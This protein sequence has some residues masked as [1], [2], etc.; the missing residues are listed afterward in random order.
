MLKITTTFKTAARALSRNPLRS[1]L[2]TLGIVVGIASAI[3]VVQIGAGAAAALRETIRNMGADTLLVLPGAATSGGVNFGTGSS[4]TLTAEDARAIASDCPSVTAAVPMVNARLQLVRGG[5]NWVPQFIEG[6]TPKYLMIRH[7]FIAQGRAFNQQDVQNA[8]QVCVLGH[9]VVKE[10]FPSG[11]PLGKKILVNNVPLRVIGVLVRKGANML[12]M[13]QDDI[14]I[15]P[16]TTLKYRVSGTALQNQN[17]SSTG[18]SNAAISTDQVYPETS[19]NLY[20]TLSPLE[21]QDTPQPVQFPNVNTILVAVPTAKVIPQATREITALLRQRHHLLPGQRSDFDIRN[22]TELSKF[23]ESTTQLMTNLLTNVALISLMVGGVGI[24]N[25]MLVSVTERTREIGLR[26]AVGARP[27]DIL[28]Q[29]ILEA[30]V[31]CLFGGMLGILAGQ[32]LSSAV[33]HILRWPVRFSPGAVVASVVIS[34]AVGM[35]FGYYPAWKASRLD[36]IE[37]LRYE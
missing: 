4:V 30:I 13:D 26:M 11:R 20:P 18:A 15:L 17:Q 3:G 28:S 33:R 12:G 31:L 35:I 21:Q 37:A 24:M 29:F 36:P 19:Q 22:M 27:G 14:M 34:V 6:T 9:T 8:S 5:Q 1:V 23:M 16:W 25:I 2:T 10:L 7:W 32:I